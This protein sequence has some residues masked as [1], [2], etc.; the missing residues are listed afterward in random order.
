[1]AARASSPYHRAM[2]RAVAAPAPAPVFDLECTRCPRLAAFLADVRRDHPTYHA[3]PVPPF[4]DER[5]RL[6][7]VGLAPG[8]HGANASG[9][10]F[11]GDH[12]GIILYRTLHAFGFASA[13]VSMS[14]GDGLVLHDCRI[15]NAVKC[16]PPANKPTPAETRAC[17]D[18]L[19]ADLARL[20]A[21][22]VIV[23]LGQV[24]HAAVLR[25]LGRKASALTFAHG[26]CHELE[27]GARWLVDSYHC[28]RYNT[29]TRRL[30]EP[31]FEAV[32]EQ[33]RALLDGGGA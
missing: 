8:M 31:M 3:R 25:A 14:A 32:F 28:S 33:A 15:N 5:A 1:M 10:P 20:P 29:Q 27:P 7:V 26:A 13:P 17:N 18:Y 22:A 19:A 21:L 11:T 4:G 12:A 6:L 23:A 16:L 9:R 24:A 2:N 30:T